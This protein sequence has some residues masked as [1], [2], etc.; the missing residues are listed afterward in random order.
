MKMKNQKEKR[1]ISQESFFKD[2]TESAWKNSGCDGISVFHCLSSKGILKGLYKFSGG[3][4]CETGENLFF[5]NDEQFSKSIFSMKPFK[6]NEGLA[7]YYYYPVE[8]K[9][10]FDL[11]EFGRENLIFFRFEKFSRGKLNY[12]KISKAAGEIEAA[13]ENFYMVDF[14][15]LKTYYYRNI[16]SSARLGEIFASSIKTEDSYKT[17]ISGLQKHFGFDRI[18]FYTV[19]EQE[20]KLIGAYSVDISGRVKAIDYD[21]IILEPGAHRFA[22]IVLEKT[23]KD[24]SS[25]YG[26]KV[27][28]LPLKI[29]NKPAGL[30]I[31]DNLL[32]QIPISQE[33]REMLKSFAS[34]I[35]M[36]VDNI[37][38]FNKIEQL[39]LYDE[40]TKL[41][42]RRYFNSRFQEEF[43]RAERFSQ[44]LSVL[45]IDIDYFKEINDTYGHQIGDIALKE[46]GRIIN[47]SLRKIDFP[48]RYGGDEII[49]MLPQA[50]YSEAYNLAKRLSGEIR[51]IKIPVPFSSNKEISL[52]ASMGIASYPADASKQE[53]LLAK[54][55]EALYWVKSHGRNSIKAYCEIKNEAGQE[56]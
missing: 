49:I 12:S 41:P 9:G 18:R 47:S 5:E 46:T 23:D 1:K 38:L 28:Y 10:D 31:F 20:K 34:Q 48:C 45:W 7:S 40:L 53:E 52:T 30:L 13:M 25:S 35:A 39:S 37:N 3:F 55:D 19:K 4:F 8:I 6:L 15:I 54:A 17:I 43:Y 33:E 36:A 29:E 14:E 2:L 26:D 27:F 21:K 56:K 32:S 42:L 22:D 24:Y 50:G 16:V 51:N 44:P 11:S